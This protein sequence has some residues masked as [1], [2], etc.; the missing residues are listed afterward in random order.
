M[1]FWNAGEK[2]WH[3]I[4]NKKNY[5]W[6]L[7]PIHFIFHQIQKQFQNEPVFFVN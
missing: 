4:A 2:N 7:K 3:T 1:F 6:I 5:A